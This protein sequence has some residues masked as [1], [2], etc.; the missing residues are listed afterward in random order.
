M[1]DEIAGVHVCSEHISQKQRIMSVQVISVSLKE[2]FI[3]R[4]QHLLWN[5][6]RST[7]LI[8]TVRR[9]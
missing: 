6:F 9:R 7:Y 8:L 4:R 2:V 5:W 3:R 1:H